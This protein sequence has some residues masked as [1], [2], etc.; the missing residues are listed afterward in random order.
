MNSYVFDGA[1]AKIVQIFGRVEIFTKESKEIGGKNF[2]D[3]TDS[4]TI[5]L[6]IIKS[7]LR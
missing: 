7:Q 2:Y 6:Q 5:C 1:F 3:F 4:K